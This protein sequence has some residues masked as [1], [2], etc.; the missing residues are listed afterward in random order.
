MEKKNVS[1]TVV[2]LAMTLM[3]YYCLSSFNQEDIHNVELSRKNQER[4]EMQPFIKNICDLVPI[5][6]RE[7]VAPKNFSLYQ[8]RLLEIFIPIVELSSPKIAKAITESQF[9]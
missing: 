4:L 6:S 2:P 7:I 5:V 3:R 1:L 9:L 8:S